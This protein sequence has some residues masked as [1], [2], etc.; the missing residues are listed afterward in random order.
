MTPL[1]I[2]DDIIHEDA[3]LAYYCRYPAVS[4]DTLMSI[5]KMFTEGSIIIY[6]VKGAKNIPLEESEVEGLV[7]DFDVNA[8]SPYQLENI[9]IGITPAGI[10]TLG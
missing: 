3:P 2:L 5:A 7:K 10:K 8:A 4:H 1:Q 9:F 6:R